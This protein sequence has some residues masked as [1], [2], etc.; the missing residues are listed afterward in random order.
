QAE[1]GIRAGHVTG[2][3]TCAL[4]ILCGRNRWPYNRQLPTLHSSRGDYLVCT[5]PRLLSRSAHGRGSHI[6]RMDTR[7]YTAAFAIVVFAS[8]GS[9]TAQSAARGM[10]P[11]A[12]RAWQDDLRFMAREM[13]RIHKNL[14]HSIS[15]NEFAASVAALNSKIPVLERHGVIVE[16]AKIVASV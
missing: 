10:A 2:V 8:T 16:M 9:G 6:T 3:Q 5:T 13:E 12:V 15:R 4:P 7:V 14:Y 1:D 11:E